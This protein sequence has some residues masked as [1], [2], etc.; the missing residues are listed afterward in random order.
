MDNTFNYQFLTEKEF[1][2]DVNILGAFSHETIKLPQLGQYFE[3]FT[4]PTTAFNP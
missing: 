1:L 4:T 3:S 2:V